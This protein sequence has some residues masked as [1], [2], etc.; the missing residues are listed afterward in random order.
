MSLQYDYL[1]E[2]IHQFKFHKAN[3]N[4][5]DEYVKILKRLFP[6]LQPDEPWLSILDMSIAG[7]VPLQYALTNVVNFSKPYLDVRVNRTLLLHNSGIVG[8]IAH[9]LVNP[10]NKNVRFLSPDQRDE[11]I[12]W[13]LQQELMHT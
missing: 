9:T 1:P 7:I 6:E 2:G 3:R 13:L 5:V 10:F 11:G 12:T 4:T 8:Q